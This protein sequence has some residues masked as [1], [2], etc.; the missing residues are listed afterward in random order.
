[1]DEQY[2]LDLFNEL[3]GESTFGKF[4]DFK[5]L[6][7]TDPSYQKDVYDTFGKNTLGEF[8]DFKSLVSVAQQQPVKQTTQPVVQPTVK[9]KEGSTSPSGIG[10]SVSSWIDELQQPIETQPVRPETPA[11]AEVTWR[12]KPKFDFMPDFNKPAEE[13]RNLVERPA[14]L[15]FIGRYTPERDKEK[16][17]QFV[18]EALNSLTLD[19]FTKKSADSS[20]K[21]LEYYLKDMGFK[22]EES[23]GSSGYTGRYV[24]V[25]SP[26]GE[27]YPLYLGNDIVRQET[28]GFAGL[29]SEED[30][31]GLKNFVRVETFSDPGI[32]KKQYLYEKENQKFKTKENIDTEVSKL[33]QDAEALKNEMNNFMANRVS[34]QEMVNKIEAYPENLKGS[35]QY[36]SLVEEYNKMLEDDKK[37][38]TELENK[39]QSIIANDN[40]LKAAAGNYVKFREGQGSFQRA[41]WN[42]AMGGAGKVLSGLYD[43]QIEQS[44]NS[45]ITGLIGNYIIGEEWD[46][47][48]KTIKYGEYDGKKVLSFNPKESLRGIFTK[49]L[50]DTD[51]TEEYVSKIEREGNIVQRGLLGLAESTPA[52]FGGPA[53]PVLMG[54]MVTDA[55][56]QEMMNDPDLKD[57][58]EMEKMMIKDL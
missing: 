15:G 22:V 31:E 18:E 5:E 28:Y 13:D 27:R 2:I 10:T 44:L 34:I 53:S 19:T 24:D 33:S 47:L 12:R 58:S 40:A 6:I 50:G 8:D 23:A 48:L 36:N 54:A 46:N 14:E 7:T 26:R 37:A 3:G 42:K 55:L 52:M 35:E 29:A 21:E 11:E 17:P 30:I 49:L 9:K 43:L 51:V 41:M 38:S 57:L 56:D 1:M 20:K 32:A 39:R 45:G 16:T 25:I 4:D